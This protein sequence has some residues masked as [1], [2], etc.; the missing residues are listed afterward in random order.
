MGPNSWTTCAN[1]AY[2]YC[3]SSSGYCGNSTENC[4]VPY[5][6]PLAGYCHGYGS[7]AGRVG[8]KG[9]AGGWKWTVGVMVVVGLVVGRLLS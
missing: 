3:C 9:R 1:S 2:G 4:L 6:D 5:C 8:R 7:G